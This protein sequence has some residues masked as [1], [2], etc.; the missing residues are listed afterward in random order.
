MTSDNIELFGDPTVAELSREKSYARILDQIQ[1]MMNRAAEE[2]CDLESLRDGYHSFRELYAS[3]VMYHVHAVRS[4]VADGY[5]VVKSWRHHDG[6]LCFGGDWFVV[7][8]QL[9]TGQVSQHYLGGYFDLFTCREDDRAPE[10]DGHVHDDVIDRLRVLAMNQKI[11]GL[12][13]DVRSSREV[14]D[15]Q[16]RLR[17]GHGQQ[18]EITVSGVE[19]ADD[20]VA[21]HVV[22]ALT[23]AW[24]NV[25]VEF[26]PNN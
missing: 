9:P 22:M 21:R 25:S 17:F 13:I 2:G 12:P 11:D 7:V 6:E 18:R 26:H 8:A 15:G 20:P 24:P 19:S 16:V 14:P 3:R 10:W 23:N 1:W 5:D 4:W